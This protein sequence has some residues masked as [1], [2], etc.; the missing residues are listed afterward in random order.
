MTKIG[1]NKLSGF[2]MILCKSLK[3]FHF[4]KYWL[5]KNYYL[6]TGYLYVYSPFMSR[7]ILVSDISEN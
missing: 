1:Q 5:I 7:D 6:I 4:Y 3:S 2:Y